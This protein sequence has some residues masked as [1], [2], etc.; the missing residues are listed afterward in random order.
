MHSTHTLNASLQPRPQVR[1]KR[2][3]Y[4]AATTT[5]G[6]GDKEVRLTELLWNDSALVGCVSAD[7]GSEQETADRRMGRWMVAVPCPR[8]LV[9][10]GDHFRAVDQIDQL[11][12]CKWAFHFICKK[13][14]WLKL[15]FALIELLMVNIFIIACRT[16]LDLEQDDYRWNCVIELV[17]KAKELDEE[18]DVAEHTRSATRAPRRE[19]SSSEHSR[20]EGGLEHHHHDVVCE[21]VTPEQAA[22]NQ[23]IVD[24]NPSNRVS[25][26]LVWRDRDRQRLNNKVRNPMYTSL[27]ACLV[28]R[29]QPIV[30]PVRAQTCYHTLCLSCVQIR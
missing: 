18:G 27:S 17:E 20:F 19:S 11:R 9:V 6:T 3:K 15:F 8:M 7:L 1:K 24:R 12:M 16:D 25:K 23:A 29:Y 26:K 2:G 21:Y 4:R 10:R 22:L 30:C 5:V 14:A 28:C 13:K